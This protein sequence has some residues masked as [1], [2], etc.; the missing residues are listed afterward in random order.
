MLAVLIAAV[1][2]N[3]SQFSVYVPANTGIGTG[4]HSRFGIRRKFCAVAASRNSSC[5]PLGPRN[6]NR[7]KCMIRL[8]CAN[9][10]INR[11]QLFGVGWDY[12]A[13]EYFAEIQ[14]LATFAH[15]QDSL[16]ENKMN[17]DSV[18]AALRTEAH[19]PVWTDVTDPRRLKAE[20]IGGRT[21]FHNDG[22]EYGDGFVTRVDDH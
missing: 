3:A 15:L 11:R 17:P 8:R 10:A 5:A 12:N 19:R 1:S 20:E 16:T 6:R 14:I 9:S 22:R 18:Y 7:S 21:W 4:G 2:I 13:R